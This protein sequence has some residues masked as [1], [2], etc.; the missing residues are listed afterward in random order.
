MKHNPGRKERRRTQHQNR[1]SD[2][3]RRMKLN[4]FKQKKEARALRKRK[5]V[6]K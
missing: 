2:G 5:A 4:E 1:V 6:A 3:K